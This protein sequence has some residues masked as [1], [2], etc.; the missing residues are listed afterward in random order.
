MK[1]LNFIWKK[2]ENIFENDFLVLMQITL[3]N[4]IPYGISKYFFK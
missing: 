2:I 1:F 3:L 4:F